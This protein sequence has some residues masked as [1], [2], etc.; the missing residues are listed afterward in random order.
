MDTAIERIAKDT[1]DPMTV[2][3]SVVSVVRRESTSPVWMRSKNSGL[4]RVSLS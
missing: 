2:S 1:D 3:I 4:S